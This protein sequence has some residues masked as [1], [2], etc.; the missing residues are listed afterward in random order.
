MDW[1]NHL[2]NSNKKVKKTENQCQSNHFR[3][4]K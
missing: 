4:F 1:E 3:K 2:E